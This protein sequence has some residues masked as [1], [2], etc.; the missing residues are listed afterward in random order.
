MEFIPFDD[1]RSTMRAIAGSILILAAVQ[2]H[3]SP[4][5]RGPLGACLLFTIV[6]TGAGCLISDLGQPYLG[7]FARPVMRFMLRGGNFLIKGTIVGAL[8]GLLLNWVALGGTRIGSLAAMPG[9]FLGL[10]I[11]VALDAV[12]HRWKHRAPVGA[13]SVPTTAEEPFA[14][15]VPQ[16]PLVEAR[17][18][19]LSPAAPQHGREW[20][21]ASNPVERQ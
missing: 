4:A 7:W 10:M 2:Y 20:P 13:C 11:G 21:E 8:T 5:S 1:E 15:D 17:S 14:S 16:R 6:L 19:D 9:A 18:W 3:Q 12:A